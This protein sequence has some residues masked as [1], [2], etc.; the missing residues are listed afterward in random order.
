MCIADPTKGRGLSSTSAIIDPQNRI[1]SSLSSWQDEDQCAQSWLPIS[2][3][4]S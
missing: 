3:I 1:D 4:D 2:I